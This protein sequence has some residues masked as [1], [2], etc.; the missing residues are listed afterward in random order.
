MCIQAEDIVFRV[1][2]L[3]HAGL[4]GHHK[5]KKPSIVQHLD[6]LRP[7]STQWKRATDLDIAIIM[8]ENPI[9]IEKDSGTTVPLR[10]L[11]LRIK[12]R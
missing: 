5:N 9:T 12:N 4:V 11:L 8:V 1:K 10:N 3:C 7:P 6:S 2:A